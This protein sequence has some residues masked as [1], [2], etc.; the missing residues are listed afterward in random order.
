MTALTL[1]GGG[2]FFVVSSPGR[3]GILGEKPPGGKLMGRDITPK[4]T[5]AEVGF[6]WN[7]YW[8]NKLNIGMMKVF[9]AKAE[10]KEVAMVLRYA[11][12]AALQIDAA[13]AAILSEEGY[14]L[15]RGVG[16]GDADT[17]AP[18]LFADTGALYYAK[19]MVR[20]A[21]PSS[22]EAF[23][24]ATRADV[25]EFFKLAMRLGEELDNRATHVLLT[26]GLYI[27]PPY[28]PVP[29]EIKTAG[30]GFL[31]S[32]FGRNRPL[33]AIEVAHIYTNMMNNLFGNHVAA[34]FSQVARTH[35][36]RSY[37]LRGA[38]IADKQLKVFAQVLEE[39]GLKAPTTWDAMPTLSKTPPFSDRFML[40]LATSM[41]A[42]GMANYGMAL[43]AGMRADLAVMYA[44]LMAEA[45]AYMEDG[46]A[47]MIGN[48]WL[49]EPPGAPDRTALALAGG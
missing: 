30:D 20:M 46:T 8:G 26:K 24:N 36:L 7:H 32:A 15:P 17:G 14:P 23:V 37:F 42:M 5:A 45:G 49:E 4:L 28:L 11:Y 33:L 27:R 3:R 34:A 44:R 43:A 47:L 19:R 25:R 16:D 10:D 31:G 35:E 2:A 6:L 40:S 48:R 22:T 41:T 9:L 29:Q 39:S 1:S 18:R 21:L 38:E 12:E 13:I